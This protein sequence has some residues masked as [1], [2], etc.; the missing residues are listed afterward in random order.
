[1]KKATSFRSNVTIGV[2]S[3]LLL[4]ILFV[5]LFSYQYTYRLI[6]QNLGENISNSIANLDE[7][8]ASDMAAYSS[9]LR[10]L[11]RDAEVIEIMQRD[12]KQYP[13]RHFEDTQR[14]YSISNA[15]M[16]HLPVKLPMHLINAD[17]HISRFSTTNYY[18]P[19]YGADS[20]DFFRAM[21]R[22]EFGNVTARTHW[23]VDGYDSMD[24]CYSMGVCLRDENWNPVGYV[25]LDVYQYYFLQ[26]LESVELPELDN[27]ILLDDE[28]H[29]LADTAR[30]YRIGTMFSEVEQIRA[31]PVQNHV[32][33]M[34]EENFLLYHNGSKTGLQLLALLPEN[35]FYVTAMQSMQKFLLPIALSLGLGILLS[36]FLTAHVSRPIQRLSRAFRQINKGNFHARVPVQDSQT[37]I[38][39]LSSD[40]ND[41][42]SS[43]QHLIEQ[44]YQN[45]LLLQ[46]AELAMLKSQIN[47]HFLYNCMNLI[48][49]AAHLGQNEHVVQISSALGKFYRYIVQNK[50]QEVPLFNEMA[51]IENYLTIYRIR[52][53][54]RLTVE[55]DMDPAARERPI[56]KML[57]Q[58]LVENAMVHGIEQ[59][60]GTGILR[61]EVQLD[62]EMLLIAV[63]DNGGGFGQSRHTSG[64]HIGLDN[65]RKRIALYYGKDAWLRIDRQDGFTIVQLCLPQKQDS[66]SQKS[67]EGEERENLNC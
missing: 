19:I 60:T 4:V 29:I 33:K 55:I 23:R 64:Q 18:A 25:V 32:I 34:K 56:L 15:M 7:R 51:Q 11:A 54:D 57:L 31:L 5:L 17:N 67:N 61:V 50:E 27:L 59:I 44:E 39:L 65:I 47:P 3:I 6:T 38:G 26:V 8:I 1:M 45:S 36:I 42:V 30:R 66:T 9:M 53:V 35:Y 62:G 12:K 24:V 2:L 49:M 41:M 63:K 22:A 28:G 14:L 46:E 16:V 52:Y 58:P 21:D 40:F 48:S 10:F 43:L 13:A 37:E 20:D